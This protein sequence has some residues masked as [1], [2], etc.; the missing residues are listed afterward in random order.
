MGE[1]MV[2]RRRRRNSFRNVRE[3]TD[4]ITEFVAEYQKNPRPLVWAVN[5]SKILR[6]VAYATDSGRPSNTSIRIVLNLLE[7]LR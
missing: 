6:K 1:Q 2:A 3:L 5:A 7:T 4:A